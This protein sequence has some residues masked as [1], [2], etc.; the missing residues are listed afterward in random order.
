MQVFALRGP[1][2]STELS[3]LAALQAL[4]PQ[5]LPL[6]PALLAP[7]AP[8]PAAPQQQPQP[9][10]G[11]ALGACTASDVQAAIAEVAQRFSLNAEQGAALQAMLPWFLPGSQVWLHFDGLL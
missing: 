9:R 8:V 4:T 5:S 10:A 7:P 6:L 2:A 1:E 11:A 3:M